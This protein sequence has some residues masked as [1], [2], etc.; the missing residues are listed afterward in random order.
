MAFGRLIS[1]MEGSAHMN[2]KNST[3]VYDVVFSSEHQSAPPAFFKHNQILKVPMQSKVHKGQRK[4]FRNHQIMP[5]D[6]RR[7]PE[8]NKD[9][10][11]TAANQAGH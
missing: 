1:G 3:E 4:R 7:I 9:A 2:S 8:P 10:N 6:L 11:S 5:G